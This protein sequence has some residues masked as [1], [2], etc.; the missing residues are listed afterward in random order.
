MIR[1]RFSCLINLK[2][3]SEALFVKPFIPDERSCWDPYSVWK[4]LTQLKSSKVQNDDREYFIT[5]LAELRLNFHACLDEVSYF[6]NVPPV[7]CYYWWNR[8][9]SADS[10]FLSDYWYLLLFSKCLFYLF[11]LI[12]WRRQVS[13]KKSKDSV[14]K[15]VKDVKKSSPNTKLVCDLKFFYFLYF[16]TNPV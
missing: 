3:F 15:I 9:V 1:F 11:W 16:G 10:I 14:K 5:L 6:L 13:V 4:S 12:C 2:F 7:C 8:D